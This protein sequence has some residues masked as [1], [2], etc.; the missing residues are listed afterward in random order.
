TLFPYTTLFR[1]GG[2]G[3][4]HVTAKAS[5]ADSRSAT[6]G[7]LSA[8]V[9]RVASASA[10]A[11]IFGQFVSF[12]QTIGLARLLTPTDVGIFTA[13]SVLTALFANLVEG[14]LRSGL[15]QRQKNLADADETAVWVTLM[16]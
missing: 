2:D 3:P 14:G 10:L 15:V 11:Q 5:P 13:G 4:A 9:G 12:V 8:V 7:S 6:H 16:L 1:S